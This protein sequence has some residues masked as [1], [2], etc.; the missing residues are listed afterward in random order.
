MLTSQ[1]WH[2]CDRLFSFQKKKKASHPAA[3]TMLTFCKMSIHILATGYS[4]CSKVGEAIE[5]MG[6]QPRQWVVSQVSVHICTQT[7]THVQLNAQLSKACPGPDALISK[8]LCCEIQIYVTWS[9]VKSER[10]LNT[11]KDHMVQSAFSRNLTTSC[12]EPSPY[13]SDLVCWMLT[14]FPN[15]WADGVDGLAAMLSCCYTWICSICTGTNGHSCSCLLFSF[16]WP[17]PI[18]L[19]DS[20]P[21]WAQPP[22]RRGGKWIATKK[23]SSIFSPCLSTLSCTY[24]D[25]KWVRWSNMPFGSDFRRFPDKPLSTWTPYQMNESSWSKLRALS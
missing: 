3:P 21:S 18:S 24:M 15:G 4:Q 16:S 10:G 6:W 19:Q 7:R 22:L 25:L 13:S 11:L 23:N 5:Q 12:F 9:L 1:I 2:H 17:H 14:F 8:P 20:D